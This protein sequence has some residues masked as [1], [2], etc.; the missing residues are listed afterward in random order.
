MDRSTHSVVLLLAKITCPWYQ[1]W[2]LT[3]YRTSYYIETR[4]PADP[5]P[6]YSREEA[7]M[8]IRTAERIRQFMRTK[9]GVEN[10]GP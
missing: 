7:Q 3:K 5:P 2:G 6:V 9:L 4:Y 8:A 1:K 10:N